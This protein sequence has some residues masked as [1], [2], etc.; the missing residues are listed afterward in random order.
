[1]K[2]EII[3]YYNNELTFK[4]L[5][6]RH[7]PFWQ[8]TIL[9]VVLLSIDVSFITF[10]ITNSPYFLAC[11]IAFAML[12]VRLSLYFNARI[13]KKIYPDIYISTFKWS[14]IKFRK[15]TN[16]KLKTRLIQIGVEHNQVKQIS[17]LVK[18]KAD[19]ERI[20]Y[21]VYATTLGLLFTP[22]W[23]SFIDKTFDTYKNDLLYLSLALGFATFMVVI[24]SIL[25]PMFIEIRDSIFTRYN[26]LNKLGEL[27]DDLFIEWECTA[28]A[29]DSC[30]GATPPKFCE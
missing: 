25:I 28:V 12:I 21:I 30:R 26:S 1:M 7:R 11:G 20:P 6:L 5:V 14:S 15:M 29:S 23:Y 3:E 9:I 17:E 24:I 18:L 22:I 10:A 19:N 27:L 8:R 16:E 4:A 13:I 2:E